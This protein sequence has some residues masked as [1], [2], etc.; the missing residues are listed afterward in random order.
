L[1]EES[2]ADLDDYDNVDDMDVWELTNEEPHECCG[3]VCGCYNKAAADKI[4]KLEA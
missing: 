4:K 3:C 1:K 2:S